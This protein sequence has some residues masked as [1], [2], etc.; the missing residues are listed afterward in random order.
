[1]KRTKRVKGSSIKYTYDDD[2]FFEVR[3]IRDIPSS[4]YMD[5]SWK[6]AKAFAKFIR[7]CEK[8]EEKLIKC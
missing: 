1:M 7:K 4:S 8:D 2:C 5:L 6:E 3:I